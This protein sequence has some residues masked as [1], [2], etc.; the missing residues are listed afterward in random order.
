M[1]V[2]VCRRQCCDVAR[3]AIC[4]SVRDVQQQHNAPAVQALSISLLLTCCAVGGQLCTNSST[5]RALPVAKW[6]LGYVSACCASTVPGQTVSQTFDRRCRPHLQEGSCWSGFDFLLAVVVTC[7][8][9][10]PQPQ[11]QDGCRWLGV[12]AVWC[13][14]ACML[15]ACVVHEKSQCL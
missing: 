1:N 6:P 5:Q 3:G 13:T 8:Q 2:G 12:R 9:P 11:P 10:Q 7:Q 15:V 4:V 14:T